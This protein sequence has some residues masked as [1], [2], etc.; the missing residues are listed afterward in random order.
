MI[1]IDASALAKYILHE[2]GWRGVKPYLIEGVYSIGLVVKEVSN[3]IWKRIH[4]L[5][6]MNNEQ[7]F[8]ALKILKKLIDENIIILEDQWIYL[9]KALEIAIAY[10]L[11]IYDSLYIAQAL[12]RGELLTSDVKQAKIADILGVKVFRI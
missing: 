3:T 4:L 5:K 2:E 10:G 8:K 7:G 12:K 6:S 1:V 9:V 11:T